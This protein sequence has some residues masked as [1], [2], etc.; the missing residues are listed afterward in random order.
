MKLQ[1]Y[2]NL[3]LVSLLLIQASHQDNGHAFIL[4]R[5]DTGAVSLTTMFRAA[6]PLASEEIE[7]AELLWVKE[8]YDLSGNNG[9]T[10]ENHIIRLAGTWVGTALAVELGDQYAIG[11]LIQ[12]VVNAQPDPNANYRRSARTVPISSSKA[13]VQ[14]NTTAVSINTNIVQQAS[15]TLAGANV[16]PATLS[17]VSSR[18][19][20]QGVSSR[21]ALDSLPISSPPN[22]QLN[23]LKRRKE[24]SPSTG[25][26]PS[27]TPLRRL[28]HAQSPAL[29]S[30]NTPVRMPKKWMGRMTPI[31]DKVG[32][33]EDSNQVEELAAQELHDEDVLEQKKLISDLKDKR[34]AIENGK[35]DQTVENRKMKDDADEEVSLTSTPASKKRT[36]DEEEHEYKLDFKEPEIGERKIVTNRRVR[37]QLEPRTRSFAWGVAA[38]AVGM[39]AV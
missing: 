28:N 14:K 21:A 9:S 25:T 10:K 30:I 26:P 19:S 13:E 11:P 31:P 6:F 1:Q 16:V 3:A 23:P 2:A 36:R 22:I 33:D 35:E 17:P 37:F 12:I 38:F 4:R 7:R 27:K 8:N 15:T 24:S 39:G 18:T 29:N 34:A 20:M 32:L 5:F